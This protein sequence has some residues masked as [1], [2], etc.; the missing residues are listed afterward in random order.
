[1]EAAKEKVINLPVHIPLILILLPFFE[2]NG[3]SFIPAA[4]RIFTAAMA[5]AVLVVLF[6]YYLSGCYSGIFFLFAAMRAALLFSGIIV[7]HTVDR[8][9]IM[10]SVLVF[11]CICALELGLRYNA[12]AA[13]ESLYCIL[14]A[15]LLLNLFTCF[16]DGFLIRYTQKYFWNGMRTRFTDSIIP[17]VVLAFL[18]SYKRGMKKI[19]ALTVLTIVTAALQL[20]M[21]WVATG[22]LVLAVLLFLIIPFRKKPKEISLILPVMAPHLIGFLIVFVRAQNLFR[23]IIVDLLHKDLNFHGRVQIWNKAMEKILQSPVIGVG[24]IGNG[25]VSRV[26]WSARLVPA[27]NTVLQVLRDGGVIALLILTAIF[28]YMLLRL[29]RYRNS[30]CAWVIAAGLAALG[31]EMISEVCHYYVYFAILP[32]LAGNIGYIEEQDEM[33]SIKLVF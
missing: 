14:Q 16:T 1:M 29:M 9:F 26:Y 8:S 23:F 7:S 32:V 22:I 19:N 31:T 24:E 12:L 2:P 21:E 10:R 33:R 25:G 28:F 4:D 13:M 6:L 3:V 20:V 18:I 5:A 30:A 17:A 27:H 11:G 15:N